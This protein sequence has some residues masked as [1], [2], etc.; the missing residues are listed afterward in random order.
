M[1]FEKFKP[2]KN[3]IPKGRVAEC[4]SRTIKNGSTLSTKCGILST[5]VYPSLNS[6]A[7]GQTQRIDLIR[8]IKILIN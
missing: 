5:E 6:I 2:F 4:D 8:F 1:N 3:W 7:L